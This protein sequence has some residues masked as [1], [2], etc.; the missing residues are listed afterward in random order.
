MR[1]L[2]L[3]AL[4]LVALAVL[5]VARSRAPRAVPVEAPR[6]VG[7]EVCGTCHAAALQAWTGSQHQAAMREARDVAV[8]GFDAVS[9]AIGVHPLQQYMVSAP[10]GRW[11][12]AP[13][14]WDARPEAEGGQRWFSPS[15]EVVEDPDDPLHWQNRNQ[16]WNLQC[17]ECHVTGLDKG[18]NSETDSY[19]T[20]WRELGV[21]C[22][23]C[24][25]PGSRHVAVARE[26]GGEP[27]SGLLVRLESR[28]EEAWRRSPG[29]IVAARDRP[30]DA[31]LDNT[32]A[33]CHARRSALV[34]DWI[35]GADLS[36][37]HRLALLTPPLYHADGQQD[38]EVYNWG[39][40]Q[41]SRMAQAGVTC[42]DCHEP[43]ALGL[44]A[45]GNAL[46]T[47]CHAP[48]AFDTEAHH[49]H[50]ADS[51]GSRCTACHMPERTYMGIDPRADHS[52][53]VPRPDLSLVLG[54]PDACSGC[55]GDPAW[56]AAAL[57]ARIGEA[58]RSRPSLGPI[59]AA[60]EGE[61]EPLLDLALD[62]SWP[63]IARATALEIAAPRLDD[64]ALPALEKLLQDQDPL[65][66]IAALGALDPFPPAARLHL[67]GPLLGDPIRGVRV[68]AAW[69]LADLDDGL[70]SPETRAA[71]QAELEASLRVDADWP[72]GAARLGDLRLRQGRLDDARSA[73]ERAIHLD[74]TSPIPYANLAEVLRRLGSD[75]EGERVLRRGLE[76]A[77]GAAELHFSLGLLLVRKGDR[78]GAVEA[79]ARA[80]KLAPEDARY[81]AVHAAALSSEP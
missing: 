26:G 47:R 22:E 4:P 35:P 59:L 11:Q 42:A 34:E 41:Q 13:L 28:W 40:F 25:G 36:D 66:R 38:D 17:A 15:E 79:L 16:S 71:A 50:A 32:C 12:V 43:H 33:P 30:A 60:G 53:R 27:G 76:R 55:H 81:A 54:A 62:T 69:L 37:S 52:L 78:A 73:Y 61:V 6:H 80:A 74:P 5:A 70:P 48:E 67:V 68:E 24:H 46:C 44:R 57:D 72:S 1:R 8:P 29:H 2:A 21:G 45:Q 14:A 58:W 64:S 7:S 77:P 65:V 23:A 3:L 18:Y 10:G 31:A 75:D 39:S 49:G 51:A 56:A 20:T 63:G 19:A 9:Y